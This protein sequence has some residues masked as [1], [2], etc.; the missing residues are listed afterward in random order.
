VDLNRSRPASTVEHALYTV[1]NRD[2]FSL[3]QQLCS[4]EGFVSAIVFTRTKY[5]ARRLAQR[6]ARSGHRA[7]ALQGNMSQVQR[8]QAM[9]GFRQRRFEI[10]VATDI[11]A[12]GI[13]V[14]QVS[15]VVNFDMPSTVD[16]YTH[17]IGRTGRAERRGSAYTF[18][19]TD[20]LALVTAIERRIGA[21]IPYKSFEGLETPDFRLKRFEGERPSMEAQGKPRFQGQKRRR[22]SGNIGRFEKYTSR[23]AS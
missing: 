23:K 4:E 2:K 18:V 21:R 8:V 22:A 5:R 1:E 6:L 20:D 12:R 14:E 10:L 19:T 15:H 17:R 9:E 13:D 16:A 7:V 11:A 3:L